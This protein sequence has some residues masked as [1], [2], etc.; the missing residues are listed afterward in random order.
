M[1]LCRIPVIFTGAAL[2]APSNPHSDA[3]IYVLLALLLAAAIVVVYLNRQICALRCR[4][5]DSVPADDLLGDTS[6]FLRRDNLV[7]HS[8]ST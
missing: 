4:Q 3:V 7:G 6:R 5:N 1:D 8:A 2:A